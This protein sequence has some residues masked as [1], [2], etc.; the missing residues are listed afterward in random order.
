MIYLDFRLR[1]D[2]FRYWIES[3]LRYIELG[4]DLFRYQILRLF[5]LFRY[6]IWSYQGYFG[7]VLD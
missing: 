4:D 2:L 5:K 3:D 7:R 6:Q 1:D